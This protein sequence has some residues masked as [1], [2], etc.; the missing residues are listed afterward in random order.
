MQPCSPLPSFSLSLQD[1][2]NYT[3]EI[4]EGFT[5]RQEIDIDKG[6]AIFPNPNDGK[7]VIIAKQNE[8][9]SFVTIRNTQGATVLRENNTSETELQIDISKHPAGIYFVA[10]AFNNSV[11][12]IKI[13][14][15]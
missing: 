10:I 14:K 7:F 5:S 8:S 3:D 6:I 9:I 15:R 4:N 2:D 1:T 13:M 11:Q 12:T